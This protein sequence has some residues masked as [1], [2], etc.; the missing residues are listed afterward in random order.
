MRINLICFVLFFMLFLTFLISGCENKENIFEQD[1]KYSKEKYLSELINS[2]DKKVF[3]YNASYNKVHTLYRQAHGHFFESKEKSHIFIE[4]ID[5]EPNQ[6]FSRNINV[7]G[8]G[9]ISTDYYYKDY[10][11]YYNKSKNQICVNRLESKL[12]H[13]FNENIW[14]YSSDPIGTFSC[15]DDT[16]KGIDSEIKK[17]IIEYLGSIN[18]TSILKEEDFDYGYCYSFLSQGFEQKVCFDKRNLVTYVY[19]SSEE[20]GK[21]G[22]ETEVIH[23]YIEK[24][25][26]P[27]EYSPNPI[28]KN[29]SYCED[30]PLK[31]KKL[32]IEGLWS[33]E[34]WTN[35]AKITQN[36]SFCDNIDTRYGDKRLYTFICYEALGGP[37]DDS[38]CE[39]MEYKTVCYDYINSTKID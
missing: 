10:F 24:L 25:E 2:L 29:F 39:K 26:S 7:T 27:S 38:I 14:N 18:I 1:I 23:T 28:N 4:I 19:L 8:G 33:C 34:C 13:F 31:Y 6:Y 12:H 22:G 36:I 3:D 15:N 17:E 20:K 9:F 35:L 5:K 11:N 30:I 16:P 21:Y 37:E 32:N